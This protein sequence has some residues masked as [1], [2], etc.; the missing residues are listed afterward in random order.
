MA[1][2]A[3]GLALQSCGG[4]QANEHPAPSREWSSAAPPVRVEKEPVRESGGHTAPGHVIEDPAG[5]RTLTYKTTVREGDFVVG[6][7]VPE[8]Y[9]DFRSLGMRVASVNDNGIVLTDG[10][11]LPF[12]EKLF[13]GGFFTTSHIRIEKGYSPG[14]ALITFFAIESK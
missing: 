7:D 1:V 8:R 5:F 10:T 4:A 6:P 12:G 3:S 14:C 11:E 9:S 2:L 13:L